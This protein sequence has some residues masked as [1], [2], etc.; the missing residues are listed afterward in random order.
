MSIK[1]Q[2][3]SFREKGD[4]KKTAWSEPAS[5]Q[6]LKSKDNGGDVL[7]KKQKGRTTNKI[8]QEKILNP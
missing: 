2:H 3:H 6:Y 8:K 4:L 5:K 1:K 7:D